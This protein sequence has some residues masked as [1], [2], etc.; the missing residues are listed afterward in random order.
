MHQNIFE[1]RILTI[2]VSI[3]FLFNTL[4]GI[5]YYN[6]PKLRLNHLVKGFFKYY[7]KNFTY[8]M[9]IVIIVIVIMDIRSDIWI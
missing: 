3:V 2:F 8:N 9:D 7:F 1:N 6:C 5:A 4:F